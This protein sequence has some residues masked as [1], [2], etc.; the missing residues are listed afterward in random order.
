[1]ANCKECI[2]EKVCKYNDGVNLYCKEDYECPHFKNKA[3]FVEVKHGEWIE[4]QEMFYDGDF[5][6]EYPTTCY[7][8]SECG[9][10]NTSKYP[11]CNCGAKMDVS[12]ME[13]TTE[14][15]DT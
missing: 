7:K 14:R 5:H 12:K 6:S 2:S 9:L 10:I 11:Y 13:I 8:C 3:D 4:T 15:K 1:M